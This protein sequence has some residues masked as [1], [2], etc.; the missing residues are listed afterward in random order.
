[1]LYEVGF[2]S[3]T[4]GDVKLLNQVFDS[5][6]NVNSILVGRALSASKVWP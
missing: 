3:S 6:I 2:T 1:M 4:L 5:L